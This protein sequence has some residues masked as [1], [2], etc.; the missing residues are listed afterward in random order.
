MEFTV[1]VGSSRLLASSSASEDEVVVVVKGRGDWMGRFV[2]GIE[3]M[4]NRPKKLLRCAAGAGLVVVEFQVLFNWD[5]WSVEDAERMYGFV[6]TSERIGGPER[7]RLRMAILRALNERRR[8]LGLEV[9]S[10]SEE[11]GTHWKRGRLSKGARRPR[12]GDED[13][14]IRVGDDVVLGQEGEEDEEE[15]EV[16]EE[17]EEDERE[18]E[19]AKDEDVLPALDGMEVDEE[20]QARDLDGA[21]IQLARKSRAPEIL[22]SANEN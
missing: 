18:E 5:V 9:Q 21:K 4:L 12:E 8:L 3:G 17:E 19:E 11:F 13:D 22:G 15:E 14:T 1:E 10:E 6:H 20:L 7:Y 2:V 16:E